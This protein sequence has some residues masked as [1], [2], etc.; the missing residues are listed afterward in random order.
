M[1]VIRALGRQTQNGD[2]LWRLLASQHHLRDKPQANE[3]PC[4]R[5]GGRHL[6]KSPGVVL[7]LQHAH[8]N[9]HREEGGREG[10][11]EEGGRCK[12]NPNLYKYTVKG[13]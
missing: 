10:E 5:Q 6:R 1:F 2:A 13:A 8:M 9:T 12:T 3:N 11:G 7:W 4:L